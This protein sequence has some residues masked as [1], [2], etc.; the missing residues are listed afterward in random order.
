MF[1]TPCPTVAYPSS[2]KH[3]GL[4]VSLR[5]R[6]RAMAASC[7][8]EL[9]VRGLHSPQAVLCACVVFFF[10]PLLVSCGDSK[11]SSKAP[12]SVPEAAEFLAPLSIAQGRFV[13]VNANVAGENGGLTPTSGRVPAVVTGHEAVEELETPGSSAISRMTRTRRPICRLVS[14][15]CHGRNVSRTPRFRKLKTC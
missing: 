4:T 12:P 1:L 3:A 15:T 5:S 10:L 14:R 8:L 11:T 13:D 7:D 9:T 2:R 6:R